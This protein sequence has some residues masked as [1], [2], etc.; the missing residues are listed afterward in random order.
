[1]PPHSLPT[2]PGVPKPADVIDRDLAWSELSNAWGRPEPALLMGIGRRRAGKSWVLARFARAV[3]GIYY[4]A[5]QRT[6]AEQL[7][8]LSRIVGGRYRDSAL[9]HGVGFPTWED[10]FAYLTERAGTEPLLLVLDEF[11]YLAEA[12]PA[13]P[14]I[15]QSVWDH[16][17]AGTRIKLVLNGS[18][19]SAMTR[20]EDADQPLYGR[21]TGR[22]HF[23]PF[24][25]EDVR[26]FVPDYDALDV[27]RTYAI[28]GGLPGHLALL[29]PDE[30]LATNVAR[31]M[32][33]PSGRLADDAERM[34]DAFLG[35]A[36]V[37][38]SILQAIAT[39]A[40]T[41]KDITKRV[42]KPGGSLSRPMKWLEEMQFVTRV[43][44]LTQNPD[45]SRRSLYRIAD[46]Y[47]A[48]WHRFVA[49]LLAAGET[50]LTPADALWAG[51][52]APGLNDYLGHPF[53][54]MCRA[55]VSRT[56]RLPFRPSRVGA[57]WDGTSQNEIDLVALGPDRALLVGEC[58]WG[59]FDDRDL[60]LLRTRSALLH[61]E[62]PPAAQGGRLLL[63][64]FSARGDWGPEVAREID[65]GTV[66]GFTAE[67]LLVL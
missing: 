24:H 27:L 38:Y 9:T 8:A 26:A 49:P 11:P 4:Q 35:E 47:I 15:L 53:E 66:L 48:F 10:L 6:E 23:P 36:D 57:W 13:L 64:C 41:W 34:L 50:S 58:K 56:S 7:A 32:L 14:S 17:W 3:D 2:S 5:T 42:G 37:H 67:D 43:V 16:R 25:L 60:Q 62:L 65:A 63:A 54:Q 40:H 33:N 46:H 59:A 22:L 31:L 52:V 44:P 28:M 30:D 29:R 45:T 55:W 1:M 21:R 20:L 18:H 51:R 12:A 39:G 61:T 19:I